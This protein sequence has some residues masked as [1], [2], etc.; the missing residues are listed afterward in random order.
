MTEKAARRRGGIPLPGLRREREMHGYSQQDL[1]DETGVAKSTVIRI[2][3]GNVARPGTAKKLANA[4]GV[5]VSVLA[6]VESGDPTRNAGADM[7][8]A[9]AAQRQASTEGRPAREVYQEMSREYER[10]SFEEVLG[11]DVPFE[12]AL[13]HARLAPAYL[14]GVHQEEKERLEHG[15][16][17]ADEISAQRAGR[18]RS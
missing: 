15:D 13:E 10:W 6:A 4:L 9:F 3:Q 16:T 7:A 14:A 8:L 1:A 18:L 17:V 5:S 12:A 11:G 2:E